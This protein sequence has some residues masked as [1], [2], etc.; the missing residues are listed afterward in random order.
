MKVSLYP[1]TRPSDLPE[2]IESVHLVRPIGRKRISSLLRA[3]P[4]I[5]KIT[6]SKSCYGRT[7]PRSRKLLEEKGISLKIRP[8]RGRA[9]SIPLEK[10]LNVIEMRRDFRPLRE[11]EESTGVPKSTVHYLVK[12][13]QRKKVKNGKNVIYLK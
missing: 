4:S 11:I 10:M 1:N 5:S 13:S 9:I 2:G 7:A 12:H 3:R 8:E 6:L